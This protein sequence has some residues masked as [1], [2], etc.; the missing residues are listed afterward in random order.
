MAL[1]SSRPMQQQVNSSGDERLRSADGVAL[2]PS[3]SAPGGVEGP[4]RMKYRSTLTE[5]NV[6]YLNKLDQYTA[7]RPDAG[8]R[9][10]S[11]RIWRWLEGSGP[12]FDNPPPSLGVPP[13][14][15]G[16]AASSGA[17][18]R[19]GEKRGSG[20]GLFSCFGACF[21]GGGSS[22]AVR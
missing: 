1:A 17:T 10:S 3:S 4:V 21:G 5:E 13:V 22:T 2:G 7:S 11:E 19:H 9:S 14:T 18:R 6:A 20:G 8:A 16:P 15:K 12:P